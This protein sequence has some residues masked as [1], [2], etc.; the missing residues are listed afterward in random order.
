[1]HHSM[2]ERL[3]NANFAMLFSFWDDLFGTAERKAPPPSQHGLAGHPVP[4]T[5][6]GQLVYPFVAIA[7]DLRRPAPQGAAPAGPPVGTP[8]E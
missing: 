3:Q 2:D 5:W 8:A 4:E 1:M 7:R 6:L